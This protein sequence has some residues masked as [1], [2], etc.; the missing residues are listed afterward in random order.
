MGPTP[1]IENRPLGLT[2]RNGGQ[3]E[4]VSLPKKTCNAAALPY[5]RAWQALQTQ[6]SSPGIERPKESGTLCVREKGKMYR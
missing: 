4:M 6:T 1:E 5:E 2:K 3:E